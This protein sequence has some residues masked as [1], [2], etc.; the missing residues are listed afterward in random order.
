[1]LF[2]SISQGGII[3]WEADVF[4][5][6]LSTWIPEGYRLMRMRTSRFS[7]DINPD[8]SKITCL[9][10]AAHDVP[11]EIRELLKFYSLL[12]MMQQPGGVELTLTAQ[13]RELK[14]RLSLENHPGDFSKAL[15]TVKVVQR[16]QGEFNYHDDLNVSL[17]E[18]SQRQ[19]E[20]AEY[21]V[22]ITGGISATAASTSKNTVDS[23]MVEQVIPIF[24]QIGDVYFV[25][26]MVFSGV[27]TQ[28][29]GISEMDASSGTPIFKAYCR[30]ELPK[31]KAMVD[32]VQKRSD[33]YHSAFPVINLTQS[34]LEPF[35][36]SILQKE[37]S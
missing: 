13:E 19:F 5:T 37:N 14:C 29:S 2:R 16:I 9:F 12:T 26:L 17:L 31:L 34:M 7:I 23:V 15:A 22:F 25:S 8:G 20:I 35:R 4:R 11:S 27:I 33:S 30:D 32:E 24:F 21:L 3:E 6:G 1:M 28:R 10:H 36:L 18:L